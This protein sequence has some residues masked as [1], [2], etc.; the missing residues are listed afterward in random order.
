MEVHHHPHVEKKR[1]KEYLLEFIMIF[2]AVTLGFFAE[3]IR[4]SFKEHSLR[5]EYIS[6][7]YEDLK[8]D[9]AKISAIIAFD[10]VKINAFNTIAEC[11]DSISKRMT[12]SCMLNLVFASISDRPFQMTDRTIKQ[13][14]NAG[15]Y[16][17]LEKEDADSIIAYQNAFALLQDF[18]STGFQ[19]AQDNVRN[20]YNQVTNF[21]ASI[22]IKMS[23]DGTHFYLSDKGITTAQLFSDD[24]PLLNRY[25]NELLVYSRSMM[26][27]QKQLMK[28]KQD[29]IT[30]L[31]YF[32]EKYHLK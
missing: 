14:A 16:R 19:Q 21:K 11:Y 23:K 25:F 32:K 9:T 30:L 13:L 12:N 15:G 2:L 24:K 6:S 29:Q 4:E 1:F 8:T 22:S 18:Q 7:F 5:K 31:G 17:L 10:Q 28:L 20:T 3:Q 26:Y 27:Q